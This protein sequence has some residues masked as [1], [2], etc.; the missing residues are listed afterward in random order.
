MYAN[1]HGDFIR[2]RN[3]SHL[4]KKL[5]QGIHL[6]RM[7]DDYI[8]NHPTVLELMRKLYGPLPKV[9]GIAV[10]LYFDHI[11]AKEWDKFHSQPLDEFIDGFYE[12]EL[13]HEDQYSPKFKF[14][15]EKMKE[16]NWLY[17]YQFEYG[18]MKA[19]KGVSSRISF[20]NVLDTA[21]R[22][23]KT[24]ETEVEKAFFEF[25]EDAIPHHKEFNANL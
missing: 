25:M 19:C 15:I 21:H 2:G 7:I 14:M 22:V 13:E 20:P 11:L 8:D 12:A 23:F 6:H 1:I 24:Y 9:A 10:D 17:Q 4:P 3:F 16:K 18:L 5:E